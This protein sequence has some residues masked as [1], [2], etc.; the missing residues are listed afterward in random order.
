MLRTIAKM[1]PALVGGTVG[2]ATAGKGLLGA[3][4]GMVAAR[5]ASRSV[6]GAL[7]VG[8][9]LVAKHLYDKKKSEPNTQVVA[10]VAAHNADIILPQP[11]ADAD[12]VLSGPDPRHPPAIP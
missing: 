1:I 6:P 10:A 9:M 11:H 4:I 7:L 5:V 2:K 12:A 3:G 8:G